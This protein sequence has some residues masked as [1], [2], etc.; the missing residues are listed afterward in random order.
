MGLDASGGLVTSGLYG[1]T[2]VV[3]GDGPTIAEA[4]HD[5]YE[6]AGRVIIPNVRYRLDIGDRLIGGDFA[7]LEQFGLLDSSGSQPLPPSDV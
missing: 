2:I 5:A 6:R 1:W 4:K 7:R 3:T